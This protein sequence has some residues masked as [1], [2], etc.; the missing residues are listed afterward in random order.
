VL[1]LVV[2]AAAA[3][4]IGVVSLAPRWGPVLLATTF[5]VVVVTRVDDARRPAALA[6]VRELVALRAQGAARPVQLF[7]GSEARVVEHHLPGIRVWRPR[8]RAVL[9]EEAARAYARGADVLIASG[10]AG[11]DALTGELDFVARFPAN[12]VL[13]PDE[14]ELTL[15]RYTP[16]GAPPRGGAP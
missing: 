2:A 11:V 1:P 8:D 10:A 12:A 3:A 16:H 14:P 6:L 5:V 4:A 7:A 13:F 15:Y 9:V